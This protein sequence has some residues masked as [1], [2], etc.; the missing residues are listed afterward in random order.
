VRKDWKMRFVALHTNRISA[1]FFGDIPDG[2]A[3]AGKATAPVTCLGATN[4]VKVVSAGVAA[5]AV[6]YAVGHNVH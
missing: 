2:E 5:C 6:G 1:D 4:A 3:G